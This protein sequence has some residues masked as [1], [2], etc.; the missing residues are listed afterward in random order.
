MPMTSAESRSVGAV[1]VPTTIHERV[2]AAAAK[3]PDAPALSDDRSTLTYGQLA[4]AAAAWTRILLAVGVQRG[5]VVAVI[6]RRSVDLPA[7]LLG[8]L[9]A[10]GCYSIV[11]PDWPAERQRELIT[12][13]GARTCLIPPGPESTGLMAEPGDV[14]VLPLRPAAELTG[15]LGAGPITVSPDDPA[16]VFW[17][18]GSTG[19]PKGVLSPHR[20]TTR[21]FG[22][23][24]HLRGG[25]G[26]VMVSI[27]A[28]AWD[29]FSL[30][31]WS[32][33]TTGGHAVMHAER[34]FLPTV[35]H[36]GESGG[37]QTWK[38]EGPWRHSGNTRRSCGNAR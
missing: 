9:G 2:G 3:A 6:S 14:R 31:L 38:D 25:P 17:T 22:H 16:C 11:D 29:G 12:R 7:A 5:D 30:E 24:P 35:D 27:A 21:L 1:T 26:S 19:K 37:P 10:G 28:P 36:P 15:E 23:H 32:M 8:I 13:M 20:A 34:Y 4:A 33:L 18:S